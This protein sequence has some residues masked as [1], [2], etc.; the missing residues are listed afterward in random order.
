MTTRRVWSGSAWEKTAGYCRA[1]RV[2]NHIWVAGTAPFGDDGGVV[3]PGDLGAQA[4]RC[5][6]II[7]EALRELGSRPAD[8]VM[9]RMYVTDIARVGELSESHR[10]M[11]GETPPASTL[12]E[13]AG[14]V[15]PEMLIE[16]EVEAI[17]RD[18]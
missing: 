16:I 4:D 5:L 2:G 14:L 7:G 3:A 11:F 10:R 18:E 8:V 13:V 1:V 6:V 9:T 17:V 15:H 12:V